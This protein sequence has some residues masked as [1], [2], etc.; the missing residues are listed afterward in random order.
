M[1]ERISI[2]LLPRVLKVFHANN[3]GGEIERQV[4]QRLSTH[5][6]IAMLLGI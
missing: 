4:C 1:I 5:P 6:N 2:F 3:G